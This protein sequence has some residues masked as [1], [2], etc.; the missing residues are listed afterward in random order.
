VDVG[1]VYDPNIHRYDHHQRGFMQTFDKDHAI[2]LSSAGLIYKHF[3]KEVIKN[4]WNTN[5]EIT[6]RIYKRIYSDFIEAI[7]GIDNGIEAYPTDI[8]PKYRNNTNISNR[9]ASLNPAWNDTNIDTMAR[10]KKAMQITGEEFTDRISYLIKAHFPAQQIVQSAI[11]KRFDTDSSGELIYLEAFCPWKDHLDTIEKEQDIKPSIKFV[12]F[13]DSNGSWR[14]Q[15]VSIR[16]GS[17]ENRL[18]LPEPWRGLRD[19][20]LL[21]VSNIPDCI[22]IHASGFIGGTK[23]KESAFQM[24]RKALAIGKGHETK[25]E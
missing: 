21:E 14:V 13:A 1:A 20:K 2:K 5:D 17:F 6:E 24:A 23:T 4:I 11:D 18:S 22:F 3:G 10:F 7:D 12:I 15:T 25:Q 9:V 8:M 16:L 19:E